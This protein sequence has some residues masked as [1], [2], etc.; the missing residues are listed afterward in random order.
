MPDAATRAEADALFLR[1]L[2][3]SG[4]GQ[5]DA[6]TEE[7]LRRCLTLDPELAA[8]RFLL[9]MLL[10]LRDERAEAAAE[11]RRALRSLEEGRARAVPF[12]LNPMRLQVACLRAIE[13]MEDGGRLR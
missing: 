11:Y 1:A 7:D 9:G 5:G 10:E 4:P 12:F 13:R 3:G 8:A 2:E 6:R